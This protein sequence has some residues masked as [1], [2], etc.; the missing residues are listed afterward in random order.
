[1]NFLDIE[2]KQ[3][4]TDSEAGNQEEEEHDSDREFIN[5]AEEEEEST[6]AEDTEEIIEEKIIDDFSSAEESPVSPLSQPS[7]QP[8]PRPQSPPPPQP[9]P[10]TPF[11][12]SSFPLLKLKRLWKLSD[13]IDRAAEDIFPASRIKKRRYS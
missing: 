10:S 4:D 1:M 5:D 13:R 3:E 7:G 2:A 12:S 11:S 6:S 8:Q 9:L